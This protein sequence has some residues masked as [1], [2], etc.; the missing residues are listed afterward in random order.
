MRKGVLSYLQN[1]ICPSL[2]D[3][4]ST[5]FSFAV[6]LVMD[7][8]HPSQTLFLL[9]AALL[10]SVRHLSEQKVFPSISWNWEDPG[11][12]HISQS[13]RGSTGEDEDGGTNGREPARD[14][15]L[16]RLWQ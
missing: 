2:P 9:K 13:G 6:V 16:R 5:L 10:H 4:V 15:R 11:L 3:R 1:C 8:L 12:L 7:L 14:A